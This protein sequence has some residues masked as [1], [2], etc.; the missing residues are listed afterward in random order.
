MLECTKCGKSSL[1]EIKACE[2]RPKNRCLF[3]CKTYRDSSSTYQGLSLLIVGVLFL[4][5][6]LFFPLSSK[7][8]LGDTLLV[9]VFRTLLMTAFL[10]L[11]GLAVYLGYSILTIRKI[12]TYSKSEL[13]AAEE[14]FIGKNSFR[15]RYLEKFRPLKFKLMDLP[16]APYSSFS[17]E[18]YD[19]DKA[20]SEENL[21]FLRKALAAAFFNLANNNIVSFYLA[22][23][24]EAKA[25]SLDDHKD[26]DKF[27]IFL[28]K[29]APRTCEGILEQRILDLLTNWEH[30]SNWHLD[31]LGVSV[32]S[33]L[34][35]FNLTDSNIKDLLVGLSSI[36]NKNSDNFSN[37][38]QNLN[39][40]IASNSKIY[41]ILDEQIKDYYVESTIPF[42]RKVFTFTNPANLRFIR[43][44]LVVGAILLFATGRYIASLEQ[45]TKVAD[46][47]N[48]SNNQAELVSRLNLVISKTDK[49]WNNLNQSSK[50]EIRKL[51][52]DIP[53]KQDAL[54]FL[55]NLDAKSQNI[56]NNA[57]GEAWKIEIQAKSFLEKLLQQGDQTA[58]FY[59]NQALNELNQRAI[60]Y[61]KDLNTLEE[62]NYIL[63]PEYAANAL[64]N[65]SNN[66]SSSLEHA[67]KEA[68]N[69]SDQAIKQ[70]ALSIM[71]GFSNNQKE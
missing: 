2:L 14:S 3:E 59:A 57:L 29:D 66:K 33:I 61:G 27:F 11:G 48:K 54:N 69:S 56:I 4:M 5:A 1:L 25:K 64:I 26:I 17:L 60:E 70:E 35:S 36:N 43:V 22:R 23:D 34:T 55:S 30:S 20:T 45:V 41:N 65:Y 46:S 16:P 39:Q 37:S 18:L 53:S 50:N 21:I 58:K 47:F 63:D 52:R 51:L 42:L 12:I 8:L 71:Q 19:H 32:K 7:H 67:L 38:S 62:F 24:Y 6:V 40:L 15:I 49:N 10:I 28:V 31:P 44:T 68:S 13:Q 9:S